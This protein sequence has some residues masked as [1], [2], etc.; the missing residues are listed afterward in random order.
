VEDLP[1]VAL[2]DEEGS[3]T[4]GSND[5]DD[6]AVLAYVIAAM[7]H[8][9]PAAQRVYRLRRSGRLPSTTKGRR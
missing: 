2:V 5:P 8:D 3:Y 9:N 6:R 4:L 7:T 1:L